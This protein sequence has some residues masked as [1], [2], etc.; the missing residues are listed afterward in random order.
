MLKYNGK[1]VVKDNKW[2]HAVDYNPLNLPAG[3]IR[4]RTSD[5]LV[6]QYSQQ[7]PNLMPDYT[8]SR[9][10][11]VEGTEDQYDVY[12]GSSWGLM[13]QKCDNVVEIL[14]ANPEGQTIM[15]STFAYTSITTLPMIDTSNIVNM[16][17]TFDHCENLIEVPT[18]DTHNVTNMSGMFSTC[19]NLKRL[20]D[21][22]FSSLQILQ[23]YAAMCS[24]LETGI[25]DTY[26]KACQYIDLSDD[27]NYIMAFYQAGI[28]T[29]SGS[30]ELAQIPYGWKSLP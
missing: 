2:V 4:V 29:A 19:T 25:L 8:Y 16:Q 27:D 28:N 6:P 5:G 14:G 26:N 9:A 24:N 21:L 10:V 1:V 15:T 18:L 12:P 11:K 20:P 13:L 3:V 30:A 23:F 22:D 17:Q 7:D